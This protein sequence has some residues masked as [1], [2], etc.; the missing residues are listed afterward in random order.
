M[1]RSLISVFAA[2][3]F[4][5]TANSTAAVADAADEPALPL[6]YADNFENGADHWQ[7]A[8]ASGWKI[9][10]VDGG[11]VY[12]QFK[13]EWIVGDVFEVLPALTAEVKKLRE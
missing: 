6:V 7:P 11:H 9:K 3:I 8:D 10:A 4:A 5:L 13:K 12:S 2:A 1:T